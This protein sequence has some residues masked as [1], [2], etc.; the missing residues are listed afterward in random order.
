MPFPARS[1]LLTS[2]FL[3]IHTNT[4]DEI[5][6]GNNVLDPE[7]F[8]RWICFDSTTA[9]TGAF[10]RRYPKLAYS[11]RSVDAVNNHYLSFRRAD[12]WDIGIMC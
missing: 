5:L 8:D 4:T 6:Y 10:E 9:Q 7:N 3:F 12:S 11:R 1:V 2:S